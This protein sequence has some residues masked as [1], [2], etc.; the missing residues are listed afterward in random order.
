MIRESNEEIEEQF[1]NTLVTG[2]VAIIFIPC[3]ELFVALGQDHKFILHRINVAKRS[4]SD[5]IVNLCNRVLY[6]S[7]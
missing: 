5:K 6:T 7:F 2:L 3:I 1:N 4:R